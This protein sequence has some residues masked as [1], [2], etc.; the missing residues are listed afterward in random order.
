MSKQESTNTFSEGLVMDLNPLTTPNNVLTNA[1]NATLITYNGNEFVLQNDLGNGRVETAKLPTGFVPVGVKEY[2]GIIYVASHNPQT[3]Q[4]QIGCFPSP[5]R[6]LTNDE[7]GN[8]NLSLDDSQ[9]KKDGKI[10]SYYQLLNCMVGDKYLNPGDQFTIAI[11]SPIGIESYIGRTTKALVTFHVA[12]IDDMG[13]INYIDDQFKV[14]GEYKF[15]TSFGGTDVDSNRALFEN[16]Q[17]YMG[18]KSGKLAIILELET[19]DDFTVAR[20]IKASKKKPIT[21]GSTEVGD[22][23]ENQ[24]EN[25]KSEDVEYIVTFF[26]SGWTIEPGEIKFLG[27]KFEGDG[28]STDISCS[29]PNETISYSLDGFKQTDLFHYKITPYTQLG[30]NESLSRTG[31]IDFS[32]LGTGNIIMKEWRY[33]VDNDSIRINYGFDLN[34]LEGESVD[35]VT[36][37]FYDVYYGTVYKN[38][39]ICSSSINGNFDGNFSEILNFKYDLKYP[40]KYDPKMENRDFIYSKL[41]TLKN[42]ELIKNNFYLVH[43]C[44][45]SKGLDQ[46]KYNNTQAEKHFMRF[47]YTTNIFNQYYIE[48]NIN[49]FSQIMVPPYDIK[50]K[51]SP[52]KDYEIEEVG[53]AKE[54]G[55]INPIHAVP[56]SQ[57][58]RLVQEGEIPT[59][60]KANKYQDYH[61]SKANIEI[62]TEIDN[63]DDTFGDYNNKWLSYTEKP[64]S[65]DLKADFDNTNQKITKENNLVTSDTLFYVDLTDNTTVDGENIDEVIQVKKDTEIC[66]SD[67][68]VFTGDML[69]NADKILELEEKYKEILLEGK[70][71]K[72]QKA[73]EQYKKFKSYFDKQI[74]YINEDTPTDLKNPNTD[75]VDS[76][77]LTLHDLYARITRRVGAVANKLTSYKDVNEFAGI[78]YSELEESA[79]D[80]FIAGAVNDGE[81]IHFE[82]VIAMCGENDTKKW[83]MGLTYETLGDPYYSEDMHKQSD[84]RKLWADDDRRS[85]AKQMSNQVLMSAL[86]TAF[87][88][89]GLTH[90]FIIPVVTHGQADKVRGAKEN[91]LW[92]RAGTND[93]IKNINSNLMTATVDGETV[94]KGPCI[95]GFPAFPHVQST[96]YALCKMY[97]STEASPQYIFINLA[98]SGMAG[99]VNAVLNIFNKVVYA[100]KV[101]RQIVSQFAE[102]V[103][104]HEVFTTILKYFLEFKSDNFKINESPI[105]LYNDRLFQ[106]DKISEELESLQIDGISSE[107]DYRTWGELLKNDKWYKDE[108]KTEI[109]QQCTYNNIP[110]PGIPS[111]NLKNVWGDDV[112]NRI[113]ISKFPTPEEVDKVVNII[114]DDLGTI[115]VEDKEVKVLEFKLE[116]GGSIDVKDIAASYINSENNINS[117]IPSYMIYPK[118]SSTDVHGDALNPKRVYLDKG[119][120][121]ECELIDINSDEANN[122]N[123][124]GE[125]F[126]WKG[127]F[128]IKNNSLVLNKV[129]SSWAVDCQFGGNNDGTNGHFSH[130]IKFY[131]KFDF[132]NKETRLYS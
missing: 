111:Q 107:S 103:A 123:I 49:N 86:K 127:L 121:N 113:D 14:N 2:G 91:N 39:Y 33:Y 132:G 99:F 50:L 36:F 128:T 129:P 22:S 45:K 131:K 88:E 31:V 108:T 30:L 118:Y 5:E 57:Y 104:Y 11:Q 81:S 37:E 110:F 66:N 116:L 38:K 70:E 112:K 48:N 84:P 79:I 90:S 53:G 92:W 126:N 9:F 98:G 17:V 102:N 54:N 114:F 85:Y 73:K 7:L 46:E 58:D 47:M 75:E 100:T 80:N 77:T 13:N 68:M 43:I 29:N 59:T 67:L 119:T 71:D 16:L 42:N 109:I 124:F 56:S 65:K 41:D 15:P 55:V 1:L 130:D 72:V 35:S 19:L 106:L 12:I 51:A 93:S 87:S 61:L 24:E 76:I 6:N 34:M 115:V 74:Y 122:L 95:K 21:T 96:I 105:K 97:N 78:G 83:T 3:N 18:K 44:I 69:F 117:T 63:L 52:S 27:V 4:N 20:S 10:I 40:E 32:L 82:K 101:N 23:M 89:K 64:S 28:I 62:I 26:N 25:S 94:H 8:P 120:G 125:S 60:Y